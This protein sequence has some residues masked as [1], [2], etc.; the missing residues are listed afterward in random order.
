Y[1]TS[2][3][4]TSYRRLFS[5]AN[6]LV[7]NFDYGSLARY[8]RFHLHAFLHRRALH[9]ALPPRGVILQLLHRETAVDAPAVKD[10]RIG[11]DDREL[12]AHDPV[13]SLDHGIDFLAVLPIGFLAVLL[14]RFVRGGVGGEAFRPAAALVRRMHDAGKPAHR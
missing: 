10:E 4:S 2:R 11:V 8:F 7:R 13:V 5:I 1:S 9:H 3:T 12:V 14:D 6:L